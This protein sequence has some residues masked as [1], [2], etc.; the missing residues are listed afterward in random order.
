MISLLIKTP[1]A[2]DLVFSNRVVVNY[3]VK[4]TEGIFNKVVFEVDGDIAEK[5]SRTGLFEI[6]LPEG[7]HTLV[8]YVKNKYGKEII[9]TRNTV[10]FS[11]KPITIELKNKLSSVVSSSIPDFLEQDYTVFVDFIKYYYMWL[12]ST[13]DPTLMPHSIE[14]FLDVDT[15]PPELLDKFYG[16]YLTSFP[17]QFSKDKETGA[18]LDVTKVIKRIKEF[19]SKKGTE[20]SFRFL[21]RLMFDTEITLTYPREKMLIASQAKWKEP[22]FVIAKAD[23]Y[24]QLETIHSTEIYALDANAN[25]VFTAYVDDVVVITKKGNIYATLLL[26]NINGTLPGS[27][28][29]YKYVLAGVEETVELELSP[30]VVSA[31]PKDCAVYDF[32]V[33]QKIKLKNTGLHDCVSCTSV[34]TTDLDPTPVVGYNFMGSIQQI[35]KFGK[36]EKIEIINPGFEYTSPINEAYTIDI[37]QETHNCIIDFEIGYIF[38]EQG[39][40]QNKYS[41]LSQIGVLQDNFYYQQNS[42]EIGAA[43]TPY[44]YSDILKETVHPVGYKAFYKYDIIDSI[45]EAKRISF[46]SYDVSAFDQEVDVYNTIVATSSPLTKRAFSTIIAGFDPNINIDIPVVSTTSTDAGTDANTDQI[47][48]S[49]DDLEEYVAADVATE[50]LQQRERETRILVSNSTVTLSIVPRVNNNTTD[51]YSTDQISTDNPGSEHPFAAF[52]LIENDF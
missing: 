21:F 25:T 4:D 51:A 10:E 44:R 18:S 36:I 6:T 23:S 9:S 46:T 16:T 27:S 32:K 42:Y 7:T 24:E 50:R 14:Q 49:T 15:I 48:Y 1:T 33:G 31:T 11:T 22:V 47:T 12:E 29:S 38:Y 19:Y 17:T 5:T 26:S 3:E 37:D 8:A 52:R 34:D 30:M 2:G 13:K 41:L 43:I 20:D 45:I 39:K 35:D 40:Y 28:V